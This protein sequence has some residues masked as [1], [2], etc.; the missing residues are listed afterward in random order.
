[1]TE[2]CGCEKFPLR[3]GRSAGG[4]GVV[5]RGRKAKGTCQ[6]HSK[7]EAL[8]RGLPQFVRQPPAAQRSLSLRDSRRAAAT[9]D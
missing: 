1:M 3:K 8:K 4:A 5:A 6:R 7:S 2:A 9:F